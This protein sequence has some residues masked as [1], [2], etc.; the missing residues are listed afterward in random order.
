MVKKKIDPTASKRG[1]ALILVVGVLVG[2]SVLVTA[3]VLMTSASRDISLISRDQT[4]ADLL[5]QSGIDHA[6]AFILDTVFKKAYATFDDTWVA[7]TGS[8]E[9][10]K[11][12]LLE[13]ITAPSF[14]LGAITVGSETTY[15]SG[16]SIIST[17]VD[18]VLGRSRSLFC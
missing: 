1:F 3:F 14:A 5:S 10:I 11:E 6:Q 7:K 13:V 12:E 9:L 4:K 17:Y 16:Y 18:N 2:L 8:G 15:P